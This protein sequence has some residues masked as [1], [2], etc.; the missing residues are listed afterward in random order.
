M[1]ITVYCHCQNPF[2]VRDALAGTKI[3]CP[4]CESEIRVPSADHPDAAT[5][6]PPV[7]AFPNPSRESDSRFDSQP[8]YEQAYD[9]SPPSYPSE[10]ERPPSV[11]PDANE[12]PYENPYSGEEIP[13]HTTST[14][15]MN[16]KS[17]FMGGLMT[18]GAVIWLLS[19]G[20]KAGR[21]PV[22]LLVFGVI[23][24]FKGLLGKD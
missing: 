12:G 16:M 6:D 13:D 21:L 24:L 3:K 9:N 14:G 10:R 7:T 5:F 1:P 15:S 11:F 2:R 18:V 19:M 23:T 20:I 17:V 4:F 8:P 22:F